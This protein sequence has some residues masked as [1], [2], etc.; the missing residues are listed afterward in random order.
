MHE[1]IKNINSLDE[2]QALYT[3]TFGKNGTMTARLKEM[4]NMTNDE[5]AALNAENVALR[6]AFR[7]RQAELE[8]AAL[9]AKLAAQK[10]DVTLDA[11][12]ENRGTLHPLTRALDEIAKI[13]T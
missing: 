10:M 3:A 13:F 9:M 2:L 11:M 1:Q 8:D 7:L 4:K 6:D 12:P 5:R